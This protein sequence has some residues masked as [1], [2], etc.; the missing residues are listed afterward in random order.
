MKKIPEER[1]SGEER[2][3]MPPS[4][5]VPCPPILK[6][7]KELVDCLNKVKKDKVSNQLFYW[8]FGGLCFFVFI[9]YGAFQWNMLQNQHKTSEQFLQSLAEMKADVAVSAEKVA[10]AGRDIDK[11]IAKTETKFETMERRIENINN[12]HNRWLYEHKNQ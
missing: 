6:Q 7:H 1:R 12:D 8:A 3:E 4:C 11:H 9:V 2:R 10:R 5:T